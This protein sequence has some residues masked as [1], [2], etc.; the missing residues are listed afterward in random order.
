MP[1]TV[2]TLKKVPESLRGDLTRW[3][4]E[5]S[6]G[7]YVGNYNSRVREFLWKRVVETVG[8]GEATICYSCRNEIGYAFGTCN[9]ERKVIDFDGIPLVLI[10]VETISEGC[11][12]I[13]RVILEAGTPIIPASA[14]SC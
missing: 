5:I 14:G 2:I 4:Q 12:S 10:P 3:M 1:F 8:N 7:V 11:S 9:T 13:L 6:T